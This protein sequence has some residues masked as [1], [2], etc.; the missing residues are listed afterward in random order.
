MS[1]GTHRFVTERS[2]VQGAPVL[3]EDQ[4]VAPESSGKS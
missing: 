3:F 2:R 4:A 1:L